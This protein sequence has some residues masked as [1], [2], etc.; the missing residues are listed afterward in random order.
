MWMRSLVIIAHDIRST[1]NIGSILR[2]ADGFGV[3]HLY[4]TGITPFPKESNDTRWPHISNKLT[5]Q[6]NKTALGAIET[7]NWSHYDNIFELISALKIKSYKIV[8]LEQSKSSIS[9]NKYSPP[10]KIALLLGSEVKGINNE[11]QNLCDELI[12]ITM[13][14][15]KESFNVAQATAIALYA[16]RET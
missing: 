15:K 16:L 9:L 1:H 13:Y 8:G 5:K 14:G 3:E 12:E 7:V 2:T 10:D 6:I 4:F 11:L